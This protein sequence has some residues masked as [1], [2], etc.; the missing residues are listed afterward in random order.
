[1]PLTS[2]SGRL[3][4]HRDAPLVTLANGTYWHDDLELRLM[5]SSSATVAHAQTV[6][7]A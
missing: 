3:G 1:M 5:K 2:G 6:T 4:R 7:W